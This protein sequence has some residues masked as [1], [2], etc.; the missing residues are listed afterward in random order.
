[1]ARWCS[2]YGLLGLLPHQASAITLKRAEKA[3]ETGL[4]DTDVEGAELE[5]EYEV[6]RVQTHWVRSPGGWLDAEEENESGVDTPDDLVAWAAFRAEGA[7]IERFNLERTERV[8]A[9]WLNRYLPS[10]QPKVTPRY[11]RPGSPTFW[12]VYSE[13]VVEFLSTA[14]LLRTA[15][16]E[17]LSI[18][19]RR[20]PDQDR[21]G[22]LFE[23]LTADQRVG[24]QIGRKGGIVVRT[25]SSSLIGWLSMVALEDIAASRLHK[26]GGC[27]QL[28]ISAKTHAKYCSDTCRSRIHK[29]RVRSQR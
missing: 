28:F 25:I 4:R 22:R 8:T 10:P 29:R 19:R 21:T 16:D 18:R 5:P 15:I 1:V 13:P 23:K 3:I 20:H 24:V 2:K 26:C 27:G 6:R 17:L 12:R 14:V 9:T 7:I 11:P